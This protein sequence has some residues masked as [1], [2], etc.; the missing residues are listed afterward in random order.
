MNDENYITILSV[1]RS[2]NNQPKLMLR[3]C[4]GWVTP[5]YIALGIF[6]VLLLVVPL[7]D[8]NM[9]DGLSKISHFLLGLSFGMSLPIII[10]KILEHPYLLVVYVYGMLSCLFYFINML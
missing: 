9:N 4:K 1:D 3:I 2:N 6:A 5:I 7:I 10:L 8:K